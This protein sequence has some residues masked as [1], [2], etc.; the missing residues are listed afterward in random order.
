MQ[1]I[2]LKRN[3]L[4]LRFIDL[5]LESESGSGFVILNNVMFNLMCM[6]HIL[7]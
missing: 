2:F 7:T 6:C 5:L 3:R 4:Y 1:L